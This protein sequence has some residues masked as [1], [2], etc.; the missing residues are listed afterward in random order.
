MG[1]KLNI[2]YDEPSDTLHIEKCPPYPEQD[3]DDIGE[4]ILGRFNPST[5]DLEAIQ[6]LCFR[7][8]IKEDGS[9]KVPVTA[10]FK[11]TVEADV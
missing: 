11:L 4:D 2:E 1:T 8:R 7:S 5:G 3:S 6:V 9:V 10:D